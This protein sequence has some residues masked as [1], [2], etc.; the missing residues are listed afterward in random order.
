MYPRKILVA[1]KRL[2]AKSLPAV[3]K[4]AQIARACGAD[5]EL[6]HALSE[7]LYLDLIDAGKLGV[8]KL[9]EQLCIRARQ[10]LERIAERLRVHAIRVTVA[11]A[12]DFP[13]HEAIV[14]RA[15]A[16]KADLIVVQRYAGRHGA[17]GLLQL[18]DWEL[19]KSCPMPLLLVKSPKPYRRPAVLAAI[20]PTHRFAKT[21]QLDQAI[22]RTA[23]RLCQQLRGT[24]HAVHAY[25]PALGVEGLTAPLVEALLR[26]SREVAATRFSRAVGAAKIARARRYLI[27]GRPIDA[28][29][30]AAQR[31]H[32]AVVVMGAVSRSGLKRL[33]IGNTAER[34]LDE[35][36]CDI[37]V[38]KPEGFRLPVG[39][40]ARGARLRVASPVSM[41]GFF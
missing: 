39:L 23:G 9:E 35:L 15:L 10:K 22:L 21:S 28:I 5:I 38:V 18:T 16:S 34:I 2:D 3:L 40:R 6:F 33:L 26:E 17:A 37:L 24:L 30:E 20:D 41:M 36:S 13:V 19:V 7:P 11:A 1:V 14:R 25:E 31:S 27:A 29:A 12:W 8:D 4:A 32:S